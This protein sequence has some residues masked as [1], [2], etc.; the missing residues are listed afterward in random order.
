MQRK[1]RWH[2]QYY[3]HEKM[4]I[5][6]YIFA[7][8]TLAFFAG[9]ITAE[10]RADSAPSREYHVKA[11][12]IYNFIKF[13]DWPK[14]KIADSNELIT[15]GIIGKDPFGNAFEAVKGKKIKNK[16]LAIKQYP[17]LEQYKAKHKDE[18]KNKYQ[19]ALKKCHILFI[20]SSEKNH[21]KEIINFIKDSSVLTIGEMDGFLEGGGI[22]KFMMEEEKVRFEINTTAAKRAKLKIRSQLLRLAKRVVEEKPPED[23]KK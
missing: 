16:K 9:A 10:V 11:A 22:I 5:K 12:F 23:K 21:L 1:D 6:L 17:G 14:E 19:D 4:K 2:K 13:V 8:L 15:I 3:K 7:V 20:C 18:Y